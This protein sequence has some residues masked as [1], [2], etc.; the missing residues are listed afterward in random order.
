MVVH[1]ST[2]CVS[3]AK[4]P[5]PSKPAER[6][7]IETLCLPT[8]Y[9]SGVVLEAIANKLNEIIKAV[10]AVEKEMRKR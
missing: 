8:A 2:T 10:N 1:K 3:Y 7:E 4:T 6:P 9:S 5:A